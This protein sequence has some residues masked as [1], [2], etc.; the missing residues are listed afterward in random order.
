[1]WEALYL[2]CTVWDPVFP[3]GLDRDLKDLLAGMSFKVSSG[4]TGRFCDRLCKDTKDVLHLQN[5]QF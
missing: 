4:L 1:M 3:V 5:S 2:S